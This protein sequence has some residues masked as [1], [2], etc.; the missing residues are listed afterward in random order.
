MFKF[1][2]I[3]FALILLIGGA[4]IYNLQFR[5]W[6]GVRNAEIDRNIFIKGKSHIDGTL[7]RVN[8][9]MF[10][11]ELAPGQ[12]HKI[13]IQRMAIQEAGSVESQHFNLKQLNFLK[14]N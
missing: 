10:D 1:F 7:Q 9:L 13:A 11:Y 4:A 12:A 2:A 14:R 8:K 5:E 6:I 3:L